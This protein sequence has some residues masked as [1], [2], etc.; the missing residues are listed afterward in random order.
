VILVNA[1]S[2]LAVIA[3]LQRMD[4]ALLHSPRL[5][6][7]RRGALVEGVRYVRG[8]PHM[9]MI[10]ILVFFAATFGMNF[11]ITSA[12]MATEEFG[13]GAS[14]FGV[15][16]SA[17]AV[18]SLAGAL[19]SARRV[20]IRLR[21]LVLAA[22]GFGVAEIVAAFLPSYV[23][24]ALFAP[25]IGLCALTLLNAANATIQL[26][27]APELRGRVMALYM[28][29]V[30][31]GAP[32]GSPII[33]LVGEHLGARWALVLGGTMTL[34]GVLVA[35]LVFARLTGGLAGLLRQVRHPSRHPERQ[36]HDPVPAAP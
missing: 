8:Q 34:I 23:A 5:V 1:V 24:F 6:P 4:V 31:G 36:A 10:L 20:T 18:G 17:L 12:L 19:L 33:G 15:L 9:I 35:V 14:E 21:L 32:L 11:S 13:K 3:Q 28:T 27:S 26:S 30:L 2:Y 7:R 25:V 22:L 16:G 29:I